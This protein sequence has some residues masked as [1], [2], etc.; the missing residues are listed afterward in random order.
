MLLESGSGRQRAKLGDFGLAKS[1]RDIGGTIVT[2]DGEIGGSA[3][4]IAPEQLLGFRDVG[5]TGD[6]YSAACSIYYLLTG[7][8]PLV[9]NCPTEQATE[10][11]IC[12]A[13]LAE[14][15]ISILQRRPDVHPYL[16]QW[17]DLLVTRDHTKRAHV[18]SATVAQ[19]LTAALQQL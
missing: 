7:D 1:F 10:T 5:P 16:A 14:P 12:L 17:V 15:R 3:A 13:A 9:L 2:K 4:F 11:Q 19:T 8:L 18:T 6:V